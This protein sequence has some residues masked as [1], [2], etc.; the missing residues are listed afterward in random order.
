[1]TKVVGK[2]ERAHTNPKG[3]SSF[4]LNDVWY[5]TYK[6]SF[7][8]LEGQ[9]VEFDAEQ[10]GKYW[11]AKNVVAST[12]AAPAAKQS[13]GGG[14]DSR[15]QSIVLQ[16]S[17]KTAAELVSAFLAAGILPL[18]AKKAEQYDVAMGYLDEIALSLYSK[19][20]DAGAFLEGKDEA[21]GPAP[22]SGDDYVPTEA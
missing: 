14:S 10:N 6:T 20:I 12:Q 5:G 16:S 7:K 15:Q 2:L 3:I 18:G 22:G 9:V 19:C 21:P 1:M 8:H 13:G 4:L 11:N 17:Y